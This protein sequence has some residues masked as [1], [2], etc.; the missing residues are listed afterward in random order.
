MDRSGFCLVGHMVGDIKWIGTIEW[1]ATKGR[2][3]SW[4]P[5]RKAHG[6]R[7]SPTIS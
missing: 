3:M 7:L 1:L 4:I 5:Y 2:G 6:H